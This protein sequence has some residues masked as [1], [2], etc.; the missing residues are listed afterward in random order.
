MHEVRTRLSSERGNFDRC[1]ELESF[2]KT[3]ASDGNE[4]IRMEGHIQGSGGFSNARM[5]KWL[6]GS[7][8]VYVYIDRCLHI[9]RGIFII[10]AK[11]GV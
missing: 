2:S 10:S 4:T 8:G 11:Q 6:L 7:Y 1:M 3:D 5:P 9:Q